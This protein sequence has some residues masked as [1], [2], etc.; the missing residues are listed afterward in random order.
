MFNIVRPG[1]QLMLILFRTIYDV[2]ILLV[3][4]PEQLLSDLENHSSYCHSYLL[5]ISFPVNDPSAGSPTETLLRLLLPLND[6]V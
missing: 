4:T 6:K 2:L 3:C 1:Y 5:V